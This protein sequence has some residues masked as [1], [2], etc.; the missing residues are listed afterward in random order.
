MLTPEDSPQEVV[1]LSHAKA[2]VLA[3][4]LCQNRK[5]KCDRRLPC[6]N[7]SK[8]GVQCTPAALAPRQRRRRFPEREL[9]NRLRHYEDLLQQNQISF[10]PLHPAAV[11]ISHDE[12]LVEAPGAGIPVPHVEARKDDAYPPCKPQ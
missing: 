6:T 7:C 9:L 12:A 11:A 2:R 5:V 10:E 4:V 3:C 8:A 1:S